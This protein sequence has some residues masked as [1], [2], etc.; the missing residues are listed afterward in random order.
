VVD[1]VRALNGGSLSNPVTADLRASYLVI[2]HDRHGHN[3]ELRRVAYDADRFLRRL[4]NSG[5]PERDF[6]ASFQRGE[7]VRHRS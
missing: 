7:Q 2:E 4:E 6:I 1:D 3:I 5:H